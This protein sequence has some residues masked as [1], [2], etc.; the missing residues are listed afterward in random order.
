MLGLGMAVLYIVLFCRGIY[1]SYKI[2]K[3][4]SN[5]S[6]LVVGMTFLIILTD[7]NIDCFWDI[8]AFAMPFYVAIVEYAMYRTKV[9]LVYE[10]E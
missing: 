5:L 9:D 3:Y 6:I 10:D 8:F 7:I 4:N 2:R 1:V